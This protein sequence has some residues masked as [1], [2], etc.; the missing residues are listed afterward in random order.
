MRAKWFLIPVS[1]ACSNKGVFLV[2]PLDRVPV[3]RVTLSSKFS[4]T[5]LYAWVEKGTVRV[6]CLGQEHNTMSPPMAPTRAA[7]SGVKRTNN[8]A[9]PHLASHTT[10]LSDHKLL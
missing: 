8:E 2:T 10:Y 3:H 5:Y 4:G 9:R 6:K 7:R 1:V